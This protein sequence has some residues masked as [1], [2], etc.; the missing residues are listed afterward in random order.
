[1][2]PPP[3]DPVAIPGKPR[4]GF[5]ELRKTKGQTT[6]PCRSAHELDDLADCIV[7]P[8]RAEAVAA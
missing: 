6:T 1:M 3:S 5:P 8:R 2:S 7:R 4:S